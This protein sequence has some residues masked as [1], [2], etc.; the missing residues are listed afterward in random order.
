[1]GT[2][3]HPMF[4]DAKGVEI[5][6][7]YEAHRH[8]ALFAWLGNVRNGFGVAGCATHTELKPLSDNRGIPS[9][10]T[11]DLDDYRLGDHSFSWL[12]FDEILE[13]TPPMVYR[14]GVVSREW[15]S[16]WDGVTPPE[17]YSGGIMG[18][19]IKTS[20]PDQ[21]DEDTTHVRIEWPCDL[22]EEF[23][24][25]TDEI[26]RLREAHGNGRMVFGFDS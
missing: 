5:E 21:I 1:M 3:I 16:S 6:S 12:W 8:Y 24:Y 9:D 15:F 10:I 4:F 18:H 2:D 23:K 20:Q 26:R 14:T 25:F 7:R 19:G 17:I 13:A 22:A 11:I